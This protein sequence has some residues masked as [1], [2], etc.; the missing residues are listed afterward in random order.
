MSDKTLEHAERI[1]GLETN[2]EYIKNGIDDIKRKMDE[3]N[4][5]YLTFRT[6]YWTTGIILTAYS[7]AIWFVLK[8]T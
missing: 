6:Y 4:S 2:V 5:R 8:N 3:Y 1:K 7:S